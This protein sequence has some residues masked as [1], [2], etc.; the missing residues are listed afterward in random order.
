[1]FTLT[2]NY[3][4]RN[5]AIFGTVIGRHGNV[6]AVLRRDVIEGS[7]WLIRRECRLDA[8]SKMCY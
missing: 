1:M 2:D 5:A 4:I 6:L 7:R 8:D 3:L